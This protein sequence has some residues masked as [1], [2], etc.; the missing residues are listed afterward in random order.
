MKFNGTE[1]EKLDDEK[2]TQAFHHVNKIEDAHIE[3]TKNPKYIEKFKNQPP[4]VINPAFVELK[5]A[6]L[7]ELQSRKLSHG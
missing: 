1:I 2:L 6:I 7:N 5:S 3:K 4:P